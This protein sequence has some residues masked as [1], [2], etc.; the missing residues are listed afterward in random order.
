MTNR[1]EP[2]P[3]PHFPQTLN[4]EPRVAQVDDF[5]FAPTPS[6][7]APVPTPKAALV[8]APQPPPSIDAS[9]EN[10]D[11]NSSVVLIFIEEKLVE[12]V[13]AGTKSQPRGTIYLQSA[14]CQNI[15]YY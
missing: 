10:D 11:L 8:A 1:G 5:Q 6:G 15:C 2:A 14:V 7:R 3:F 9:T 4:A 13:T 12:Q